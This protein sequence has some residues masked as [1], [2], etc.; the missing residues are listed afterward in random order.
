MHFSSFRWLF[1]LVLFS[2]LIL[3]LAASPVH[4]DSL[5]VNP[6][7]G[8][9]GTTFQIQGNGFNSGEGVQLWS[10]YPDGRII[11]LE[12]T[13]ADRNGAVTFNVSTDSSFPFGSYL[14][15]AH[16]TASGDNV[17][18]N[19]IIGNAGSAN[20]T[21]GTAFCQGQNFTVPGFASG[22]QVVFTVRFPNGS[23]QTLGAV[24]SD[25][26]G[27][28]TFAV[29]LQ[30]GLPVGTYVISAQ[31]L[32]SGHGTSDTLTF[33]GRTLS[34]SSCSISLGG[35]IPGGYVPGPIP[36]NIVQ[37]RGPGVYLNTDPNQLYYFDCSWKWRPMNGIIYFLVLGFQPL[38]RVTVSYEILGIQGLT[39][40]ATTSA[41]G[42]GNVPFGINSI[43]MIPGHYHW[44]FTA[45]S[46]RY[47]GH[48]DHP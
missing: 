15:L 4:A 2:S 33:D 17:Y 10:Q 29:P 35:G 1:L 48:Y 42:Y 37:Y 9:P 31:G 45:S 18:G 25:G 27:N 41:D 11:H 20:V 14:L 19:L 32:M 23:V 44:W 47:C 12:S 5:F 34:G 30:A 39:F 26:S 8:Q 13:N 22:E 16:G 40:Y 24:T 43:S 38:E 46:A 21:T 7:S 36:K 3:G 28:A 6:P